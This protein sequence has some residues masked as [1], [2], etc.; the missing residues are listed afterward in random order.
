MTSVASEQLYSHVPQVPELVYRET[1]EA[2]HLSIARS[3]DDK[4]LLLTG[5]S[6]TTTYTLILSGNDPRGNFTELVPKVGIAV[7]FMRCRQNAGWCGWVCGWSLQRAT[8]SPC[9]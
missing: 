7:L 9:C 8:P 6:E 4:H 2:F 5:R 1:D 3:R